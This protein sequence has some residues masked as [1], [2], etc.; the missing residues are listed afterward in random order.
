MVSVRRSRSLGFRKVRREDREESEKN[1]EKRRRE[2]KERDKKRD[3]KEVW[4]E[5]KKGVPCHLL[6]LCLLKK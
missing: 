4:G 6:K 5:Q 3:K 2:R 1:K